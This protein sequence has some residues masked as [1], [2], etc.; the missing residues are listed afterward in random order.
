MLWNVDV[1]LEGLLACQL[2]HRVRQATRTHSAR[3][4]HIPMLSG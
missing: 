1:N 4:D 2:E 3:M